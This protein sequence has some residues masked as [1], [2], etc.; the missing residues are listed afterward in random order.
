MNERAHCPYL[1]LRQNRAIR[2]AAPTAEHRCY[3]AGDA[4]EIP[5]D[6]RAYCLSGNHRTCPL[7]TGE[8]GA[9][10]SGAVGAA[11]AL[12]LPRRGQA[13]AGGRDTWFYVLVVGLTLTITAVWLGIGYLYALDSGVVSPAVASVRAVLVPSATAEPTGEPSLP[14]TAFA[15]P[16]APQ[17]ATAI[18]GADKVLLDWL[19]GRPRFTRGYNIARSERRRGPWTRLNPELHPFSKFEDSGLSPNTQY[20]YRITTVDR[21]GRESEAMVIAVRTLA[22]TPT[23]TPEPTATPEPTDVPPVFLP[24]PPEP[25]LT[26]PPT[27][28]PTAEPL[29]PTE[30]PLGEQLPEPTPEPSP[31]L[32]T[33]TEGLPPEPATPEPTPAAPTP[34]PATAE[35]TAEAPTPE[36]PTPEP[37]TP[38]P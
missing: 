9:T 19:P 35:P 21:D 34:E 8:W 11:G 2:F 23:P 24:L 29:P 16:P 15:T 22:V 36:P 30:T 10:T 38:E 3:V 31:E 33:P 37:P 28:V 25:T 18:L 14:P 27:D 17:G 7:Y 4:Q 1:G 13:R 20:F 32:P 12:A 6:Q 5:V 26:P